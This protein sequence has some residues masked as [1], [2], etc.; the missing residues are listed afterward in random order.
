MD[1]SIDK[2]ETAT[3]QGTHVSKGGAHGATTESIRN[4]SEKDRMIELKWP[5]QSGTSYL[6]D[7]ATVL[8]IS[9]YAESMV[10]VIIVDLK[11]K[12]KHI[13]HTFQTEYPPTSI[14]QVNPHTLLVGTEE[15]VIEL[16]DYKRK[17]IVSSKQAHPGSHAGVST[18]IEVSSEDPLIR[19]GLESEQRVIATAAFQS[20]D[21][22]FWTIDEERNEIHHVL[23]FETTMEQGISNLI[24]TAP[25]QFVA[26]DD[27]K[28]LKFYDFELKPVVEEK[29]DE[30]DIAVENIWRKFDF[31]RNNSLQ[32]AELD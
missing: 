13:V 28:T 15:G 3:M 9:N 31:D 18:I 1:E 11:T 23:S 32:G 17:E 2:E 14:F 21:I 7:S 26:V 16:W 27:L 6:A 8:C 10:K 22:H 24:Q 4:P 25:T 20:K 12:K 30:V 19:E 5:V 29:K